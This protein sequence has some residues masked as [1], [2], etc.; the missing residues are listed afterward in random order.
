M[1]HRLIRFFM[2]F[3]VVASCTEGNAP[4]TESAPATTDAS[5]SATDT[6]LVASDGSIVSEFAGAEWF[7]GT[8]PGAGTAADKS[9]APIVVGMINQENSPVGSFPEM[10]AAV[11]AA[12]GWIN[13]ELGG[14]NGRPIELV[15]C[16]TSFSVEQSQACAQELVQKGAVAVISGI[17]ITA[18][19]SLPI[20]E[21]NG[22]PLISAL[23]TTLAELRNEKVVS[24]SGSIT[25]AYVAF[26]SHA[27]AQG[28]TKVAIA[29]GQ[30]ESFEV[31][32]KEY[33]AKVAE[34]L[35]LKTTLVPFALGTTDY[36]PVIQ[37]AIDS[38]AEA[39]IVAAADTA[40]VPVITTT[41]DLGYTGQVYSVGACAAREIVAEIPDEIQAR[42]I[43]NSEGPPTSETI[44]GNLFLAATERYVDEPAGGSGTVSFRAMMNLWAALV[45]VD[46]AGSPITPDAIS[47]QLLSAVDA[48]SFWGHPYTCDR[49]QVPGFP[50]LC[51]P[52]QTLFKVLDDVGGVTSIVDE[53]IDVPSYVADL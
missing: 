27:A 4:G 44:E 32:A 12:V 28:A 25:G 1:S 37:A 46:S 15:P 5:T 40:C 16:I 51:S 53:W 35:G 14:V 29:Y 41:F 26:I 39:V 17:D 7:A 50:A 9:L 24:F 47:E 31:P 21:Q 19:G 23:P 13:A 38:G 49:R 8:V 30:F 36:L 34:K 20:L 2:A 22:I 10:R 42:I 45:A 52:Q 48:P 3:A 18:N 6:T 43:F 11:Q 33:G